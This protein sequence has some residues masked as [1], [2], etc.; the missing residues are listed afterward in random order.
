[1]VHTV[2]VPVVRIGNSR[3]IRIPKPLLEQLGVEN[4]VEL[5][6]R[7]GQMVIRPAKHPRA[8]WEEAIKKAQA[9]PEKDTLDADPFLANRFDVEEWEW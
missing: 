8:G 9:S 4:E 5:E 3:G 1:M 7:R 6:V 2:K